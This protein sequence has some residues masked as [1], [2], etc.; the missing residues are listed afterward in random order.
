MYYLMI[1]R[2]N[3]TLDAFRRFPFNVFAQNAMRDE[4][5]DAEHYLYF[6]SHSLYKFN[7]ISAFRI[8]YI[9]WVAFCFFSSSICVY[10]K[11]I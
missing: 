9:L 1:M 11:E 4:W 5:I 8:L 7:I 3:L 10:Y 2:L 6:G